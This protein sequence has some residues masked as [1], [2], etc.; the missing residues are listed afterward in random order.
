MARNR[1]KGATWKRL[2]DGTVVNMPTPDEPH[3]CEL[4]LSDGTSRSFCF[5]TREHVRVTAAK[6]DGRRFVP[7]PERDWDSESVE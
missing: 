7:A 4:A 1:W 3:Q 6:V 5:A 2:G